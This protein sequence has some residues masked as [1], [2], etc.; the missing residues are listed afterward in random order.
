M[1][2]CLY[3]ISGSRLAFCTDHGCTLCDTAECLAEISCT[4]YKWYFE[5]FFINVVNVIGR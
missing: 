3:N 4:T 1:T 2:Y 5:L